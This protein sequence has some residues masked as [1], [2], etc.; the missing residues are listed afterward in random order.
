M[1]QGLAVLQCKVMVQ[2]AE[3]TLRACLSG[4][5][6]VLLPSMDSNP[7]S[8]SEQSEQSKLPETLQ[9]HFCKSNIEAIPSPARLIVLLSIGFFY[10]LLSWPNQERY[11]VP[12]HRVPTKLCFISSHRIKCIYYYI[13]LLYY[14]ST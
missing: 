10:S 8:T 12:F 9:S 7:P 14:V 4:S 11:S 3:D 13:I 5:V 6:V 2:R 1:P